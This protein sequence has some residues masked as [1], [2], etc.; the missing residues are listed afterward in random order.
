[1]I[2]VDISS[3]FDVIL[4]ARSEEYFDKDAVGEIVPSNTVSCF[5]IEY[6]LRFMI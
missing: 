2:K 5:Y 1:M 3:Q 6:L 4:N